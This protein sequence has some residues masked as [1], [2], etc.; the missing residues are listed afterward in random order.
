MGPLTSSF[1][2]GKLAEAQHL[3]WQTAEALF[4]PRLSSPIVWILC[5]SLHPSWA[6]CWVPTEQME[7]WW[8][9]PCSNPEIFLCINMGTV[10][11]CQPFLMIF[12]LTLCPANWEW[13]PAAHGPASP[14][15]LWRTCW[16]MK[17]FPH[18]SASSLCV[19]QTLGEILG[20]LP[21]NQAK[22]K[23]AY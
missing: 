20:F 4:Q 18:Y 19:S 15:A 7:G 8:L 6:L 12:Q 16:A 22:S 21:E 1:R 3:S 9:I 10:K 14:K 11:H 13:P 5:H 2:S 23:I 17:F